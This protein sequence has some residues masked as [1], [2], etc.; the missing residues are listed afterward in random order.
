MK[1]P[2]DYTGSL[3]RFLNHI[4]QGTCASALQIDLLDPAVSRFKR[5]RF[6][7]SNQLLSLE[8]P[9]SPGPKCHA[10]D[11]TKQLSFAGIA[12]GI[13]LAPQKL[14]ASSTGGILSSLTATP[15]KA[16]NA[17]KSVFRMTAIASFLSW[18]D[19]SHQKKIVLDKR[20][21]QWQ[22]LRLSA[23]VWIWRFDPRTRRRQGDSG[24]LRAMHNIVAQFF[25]ARREVE[26][27]KNLPAGF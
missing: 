13:F 16:A 7:F 15:K 19:F 23:N 10:P 3:L 11:Q 20:T 12:M 25:A 2:D 9:V 24:H 6:L 17:G 5:Q 22:T 1:G 14:Q 21:K 26:E 8:T 4:C 27:R 18:M